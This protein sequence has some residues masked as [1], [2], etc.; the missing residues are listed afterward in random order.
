MSADNDVDLAPATRERGG[1]VGAQ[2]SVQFKDQVFVENPD[3]KFPVGDGDGDL[4]DPE[5]Q[6]V[7]QF[8][9]GDDAE[10]GFYFSRCVVRRT[11]SRSNIA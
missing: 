7:G 1:E 4:L 2:A 5:R 8:G 9:V 11:S 10:G 3:V 6:V